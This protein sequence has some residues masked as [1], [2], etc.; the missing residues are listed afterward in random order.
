[1]IAT[2]GIGL[3]GVLV[4]A[5]AAAL[6]YRKLCQR[7][8]ARALVIDS[9]DGIA[10]S[11]YVTIGGIGQWIQIRGADTSNPVLLFL[12]GSGMTMTPFTP[13]LRGWEKHFT[14]VQWDRRG[15]GRTLRRNGKEADQLTFDL[16]AED[17]IE[18]AEYL[19]GRLH[20]DQVILVGHSQGSIVGVKM[21]Q[22][23]P[24]LFRAYVGTGQITDMA[25]N[26]ADS[27]PRALQRARA[28]GSAKAV[29]ELEK[30]GRP[31]Y[32]LAR[33]W[34]VKQ[35]WSF[36]TDPELRAWGRK[37]LQMVLTAPHRSLWDVWLFNTAFSYYP[38]PLYEETM[39]WSAV[40][41][42]TSFAIPVCIFQGDADEQ[43]LTCLAQEYFATIEAPRKDL[44]L[45]PGGGHCAVL[46][47]PDAFLAEL[48]ARISAAEVAERGSAGRP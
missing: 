21:A 35:R 48:R 40:A 37:S 3:A 39:R 5:M 20:T 7:R 30:A 16:M 47:Q 27:Y 8:V 32:S 26:E 28:S 25:R 14:V 45:L 1:M 42:G 9:P 15:V 2:V 46:M 6:G 24:G 23:R 18:V 22:R 38:Q 36:E 34:L 13:V 44:V 19:C 29:K 43:T 12:H 17:G 41:E 10:E 33:T 11:G 4:L 31:P